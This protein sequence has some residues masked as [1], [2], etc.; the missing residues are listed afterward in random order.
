MPPAENAQQLSRRA[1]GFSATDLGTLGGARSTAAAINVIGQVVGESQTASGAVHAFLWQPGRGM[2]DL[3]TLG[4][5]NSQATA[6]NDKGQIVGSANTA[7][8]DSHAALW[9]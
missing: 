4:G 6:I 3:G 2:L 1:S 8:G 7:S 5:D 9:Q